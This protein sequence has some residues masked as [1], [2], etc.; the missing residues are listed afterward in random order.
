MD[1]ATALRPSHPADFPE[2]AAEAAA[3]AVVAAAI[4]FRKASRGLGPAATLKGVAAHLSLGTTT[5]D[6]HGSRET[7]LYA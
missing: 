7:N 6:F 5:E 4:D 1:R 3:V 2:V